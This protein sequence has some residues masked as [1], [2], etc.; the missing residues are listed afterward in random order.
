MVGD[1]LCFT[2]PFFSTHFPT[3]NSISFIH[4]FSTNFFYAIYVY[5]IA[6]LENVECFLLKMCF[7][8]SIFYLSKQKNVVF[9]FFRDTVL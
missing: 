7:P 5:L 6:P 4:N 1:F 3:T 9:P 8:Y 2:S